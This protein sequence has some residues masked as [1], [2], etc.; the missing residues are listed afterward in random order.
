[1]KATSGHFSRQIPGIALAAVVCFAVNAG[2]C[3]AQQPVPVSNHE[4]SFAG[5]P[6][7][8]VAFHALIANPQ[9]VALIQPVRLSVPAGA[10]VSIWNGSEFAPAI[11]PAPVTGLAVGPVARYQV[12]FRH[13]DRDLEVYPS[14]ELIGRLTPP[15]GLELKFPVDLVLTQDDLVQS[16][17]GR[18][19]TRVVYLENP[20]TALP[21]GQKAGEQSFVD[22]GDWEDPLTV[23][24]RLGRPMAIVRMG[25]RIPTP[26]EMDASFHFGGAPIQEFPQQFF[27]G[28]E[29]VPLP[30]QS[31]MLSPKARIQTVAWQEPQ[32]QPVSFARPSAGGSSR[33]RNTSPDSSG[34][35]RTGDPAGT[36]PFAGRQPQDAPG[37]MSYPDSICAAV[38]A[39]PAPFQAD[40]SRPSAGGPVSPG[41]FAHSHQGCPDCNPTGV[42]GCGQPFRFS[43]PVS[44]D[45]LVC[46]GDDRN[47]EVLV[48]QNWRVY[49]L[50]TE[51]TVGHFDT[52]DGRRLVVPSNRTCIYSPRFASVRQIRDSVASGGALKLVNVTD[53]DQMQTTRGSDFSSTTLQHL[54]PARNVGGKRASGLADH[55]RGVLADQVVQMSGLRNGFKPYEDLQ[56]MRFGKYQASESTRLQLGRQSAGVWQGND[57]MQILVDRNQPVVVDDAL[58]LQELV[59]VNVGD[60]KALLRVCKIASKIAALPGE[61]VEFTLRFDNVG[62]QVI[63]NVTILDSL[64]PRL[65]FVPQSAECSLNGEFLTEQNTGESLIL[66]WEIKEPL[67]PGEGGIIRF[68]CRVR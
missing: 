46:D 59:T 49:G 62:A 22:I 66:R 50:D 14:V 37:P 21:F 63:G 16:C 11:A 64:T 41:G 17:E 3:P 61:E 55:T 52:L 18:M 35:V 13:N 23:A 2:S 47:L 20:E 36:P 6:P 58:G 68:R 27:E 29:E 53:R 19:V 39:P 65:E 1:M 26:G 8:M 51:D 34:G 28:Q 30:G 5:Q 24:A 4:L 60:G 7:G 40:W 67:K 42:D 25:S 44:R 10:S 32:Q 12:R 56:M 15:P 38:Q 57:G 45:E 48:D 43:V 33:T 31:G 54:M 9:W